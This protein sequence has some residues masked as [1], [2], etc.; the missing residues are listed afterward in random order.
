MQAHRIFFHKKKHLIFFLPLF[1][2]IHERRKVIITYI[3]L[4][5]EEVKRVE[6]NTQKISANKWEK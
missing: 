6:I 1:A 3:T 5:P 2:H 4:S